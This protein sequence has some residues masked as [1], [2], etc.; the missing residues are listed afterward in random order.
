VFITFFIHK[1]M[2]ITIFIDMDKIREFI[3]ENFTP[4]VNED[5]RGMK[6]IFDG[7]LGEGVIWFERAKRGWSKKP[8][9]TNSY[10]IVD[11]DL[12][13]ILTFLS[14]YYQINEDHY[15]EIR[16]MFIEMGMDIMDK[17]TKGE[18]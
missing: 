3:E 4:R 9:S 15:Q 8:I 10:I 1:G 12:T 11:A 17:H 5:S 13:H 14:R 7:Q 16:R 18:Q 6:V 2:G